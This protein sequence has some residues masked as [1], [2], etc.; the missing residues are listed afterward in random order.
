ML[1]VG[2]I[3]AGCGYLD[4][5]EI[6]EAVLTL[7]AL[8]KAKVEIHCLAPD[9][10]QMHVVNHFTGQPTNEKRSV[11][12]EAARI[13]R[14]N[15]LDVKMIKADDLDA[16]II[17][18]GYGVVKNIS[19]YATKGIDCDINPDVAALVQEM[20][21]AKKPIGAICIAPAM[22]AKILG[23]LCIKATLTIG[24]EEPTASDIGRM[25]CIHKKSRVTD[26]VTDRKNKIVST[27]AYM[28][29]PSISHVAKGI[30]KLV[31]E[32]VGMAKKKKRKE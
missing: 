27:P 23:G 10:E 28:L 31:K 8:D 17:P 20:A 7:L 18:G 15:I 25:G 12:V 9:I 2:V 13:A 19:T 30:D 29:G 16:L 11:L 3:L 22:I 21:K 24:T 32:V 6:Q 26:I 1:Q 14:G 5:A 4:G